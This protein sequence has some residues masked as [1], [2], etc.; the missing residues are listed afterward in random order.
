MS[1]ELPLTY[2]QNPRPV[3]F[4][5]SYRLAGDVLTVDTGRKEIV[6]PLG[7]VEQ[8]RLT[9][10]PRSMARGAYQTK[11]KLRDGT[12]M[13]LTSI[14]WRRMMDVRRQDAEYSAFVPA[15]LARIAE[16]NP[17]ARFVAGKPRLQWAAVAALTA[18]SLVAVAIFMWQALRSG[19]NLA[20]LF[21]AAVAAAGIW[22]LEPI[23]RLNRPRAFTSGN[24]PPAL[25]P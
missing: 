6:I 7:S 15:L 1:T 22:Q 13:K 19:A 16:A 12:I 11:L 25:L 20:A 10:E 5:V 23:V 14:S 3:G 24:V 9:Y 18:V 8:A 17:R 2:R 21:G 4:E